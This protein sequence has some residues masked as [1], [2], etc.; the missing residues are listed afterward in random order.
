MTA[1]LLI[2]VLLALS[3][4]RLK[5]NAFD[6]M[7]HLTAG[8]S[9]WRTG[10][11]RLNCEQGVLPQCWAAIPVHLAGFRFPDL[12]QQWWRI[13]N[14]WALGQQLFFEVGNDLEQML[15]LARLM[16]V[17]LGVLLG[18][19][20]YFW[21]RSLFGAAAGI[22]SLSLYCFSPTILAHTQLITSDAMLAFTMLA[23]LGA[24]WRMLHHITPITVLA[25]SAATAAVFLSKASALMYFPMVCLLMLIRLA[26]R[27]PLKLHI[28]HY[29]LR[30]LQGPWRIVALTTVLSASAVLAWIM[31]W[32]AYG[33]RYEAM[34]DAVPGN[35]RLNTTW[36]E[37]L[38][39]SS[40]PMRAIGWLREFRLFPEAYLWGLAFHKQTALQNRVGYLHGEYS[41]E[42]WW[43]FFPHCFLIKTPVATMALLAFAAFGG[44]VLWLRRARGRSPWV[45]A[46]RAFYR[47]A[48]LWILLAVYWCTLLNT[49]LNIGH[50]HLLV[51]YPAMF[52]LA[53]GAVAWT[54]VR[55]GIA[56]AVIPALIIWLA[57]DA[58]MIWP[59]YLSYFNFLIGGPANGHRHLV[60]SSLDWG[61][62][63]PY[64]KKYVQ[65]SGLDAP[66]APPLYL[67]YF[68]SADPKYYGINARLL[69]G[70]WGPSKPT[71]PPRPLEAGTYIISVTQLQGVYSLPAVG[72]WCETYEQQYRY[73][74]YLW[75]QYRE[76][77]A[78]PAETMLRPPPGRF[79][80]EQWNAHLMTWQELRAARLCAYLRQHRPYPDDRIGYSMHVYHLSEAQVHE[81]TE[82]PPPQPYYLT[83][84]IKGL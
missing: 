18:W 15:F 3:S 80:E 71:S 82:G 46:L 5:G 49:K 9:Y 57:V 67:L 30:T 55:S 56:R 60:D 20:V 63:L 39:D 32:S 37:F 35:D 75:N 76:A 36:D 22:V 38:A 78:E 45:H 10:D 23:G 7:S 73:Y 34:R 40:M 84:Q 74:Q 68:G 72:P 16:I 50:R 53:G 43:N 8:L 12:D 19:L 28:W 83:P 29:S 1:L 59:H 24:C 65:A 52:I 41:V 31:I 27:R 54:K 6:E 33:L 42:G 61:Q 81:A 62:D 13:S 2:Y 69:P 66:G 47:T 26:R 77:A 79:T 11:F 51:T 25:F 70:L 21:S 64:L 58:L 4:M 44:V 14:E 48:P 17:L